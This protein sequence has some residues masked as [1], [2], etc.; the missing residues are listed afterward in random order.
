MSQNEGY[1]VQN[2]YAVDG[3]GDAFYG[4]YFISDLTVRTKINVRI[5]TAGRTDLIQLDFLQGFLSGS[6]LFGFGSICGETG[7]E[8][9]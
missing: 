5:F 7:D 6:S 4:Q 2:F 8:V 1:I 9:L 3:F